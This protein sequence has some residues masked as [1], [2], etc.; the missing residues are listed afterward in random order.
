MRGYKNSGNKTGLGETQ[1]EIEP[2]EKRLVGTRKAG[3]GCMFIQKHISTICKSF[4]IYLIKP[5]LNSLG[6]PQARRVLLVEVTVGVHRENKKW[7][8]RGRPF[9]EG[10]DVIRYALTTKDRA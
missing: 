3:E 6:V 1:L 7:E 9:V 5:A 10:A 4:Y 2:D 8:A